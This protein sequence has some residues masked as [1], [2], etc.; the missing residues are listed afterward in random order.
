MTRTT[1]H[2]TGRADLLAVPAI[3]LGFHPQDSI[4]ILA[5]AGDRVEFGARLDIDLRPGEVEVVVDQVLVAA[6][7]LAG[8]RFAVLGFSADV[9]WAAVRVRRVAGL[10]SPVE[11]ALVADGHHY[12]DC[13]DSASPGFTYDFKDCLLAAQAV[14]NGVSP[15]SSRAEAVAEV[16][17]PPAHTLGHLADRMDDAHMRVLKLEYDEYLQHLSNLCESECQL[18]VDQAC[19]LACLLQ[20]ITMVAEILAKLNRATAPVIRRRL[21]QARAVV[22][23]EQ[24]HNV[25]GLLGISCW[26]SGA[27]AQQTDCM[28]QLETEAPGHLLFRMLTQ[29]HVRGLP[30]SAWD[31]F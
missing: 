17:P 26:L 23:G 13:Q 19:E 28:L 9:G 16:Q 2:G 6:G 5:I 31:S 30:P 3:F 25:I 10:L 24:A 12:W 27:G 7:R 22:T 29:I 11:E 21:V 14:Y 4:V 1:I 8:P 18:D 15:A 20:D